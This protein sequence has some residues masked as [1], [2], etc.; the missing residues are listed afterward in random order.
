MHLSIKNQDLSQHEEQVDPE[1][2]D[3]AKQE[4]G[5]NHQKCAFNE[6]Y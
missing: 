2:K 5:L 4:L 1:K 3:L 6:Q